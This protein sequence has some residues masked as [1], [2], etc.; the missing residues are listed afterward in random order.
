MKLRNIAIIAHVDHGKTTLVDRLLQ[1][2]GAFRE[3]QRVAERVMDSNDLERERGITILAKATSVVWKGVRVNI[4]DTPGHADFGG[5]VERILSMVDGAIVLV[6][7]AEGPMPQ[8]KFV[9]GKALKIGLKPIVC[10]NK[11]DKHDAR[12][13]E[14]VNEC[15]DLFAALDATDEQLDFPII[16]G[17][18]KQGWMANS[19][20]GP[21]ENMAPL[22]DLVLSHVEPPKVGA[23][24]FRMLGTLLEANPYLGRIITG[25]IFSG[26]IK[27][28]APVKVL[29]RLGH[30][31]ETGRVS[32]ILAFRGIE[33]SPIEEASAG[34]IVA[35][36]GLEKF[37]VADTL[38]SPE[39]VEPLLAQ[40][41]DPPTLSMTFM[42]NDS[43]L[44]GTEGDKVTS[45][46]IRDRLFKEA[47]GNVALRVDAAPNSD[48]YVVSGRGELQLAI[49][50]ETMRRE[51][52]ELGVSRPKVLFNRDE[53]SGE[54]LEPIEEVVI[55]V[56]EEHSGV[57]VQKMS[58][59][60][61]EMIEMRPS[62][63][64]RL[65]LVFLAPTRGLIG[66]L[67]ELLTDT[68]GT[69]IMNRVFHD[70]GA[71]RGEIAGRRN[72]V[73]IS[74]EKGEAVAYAMWNLED[75]GPMMIEPGWKV[76]QGMI[77]GQHSRDNDLEVNVLKGKKL[78]NIRT[79]SKDEAVRLTPP[80]QMTLEKALAY[81][82]DDELVEVTPKSIRLRKA[83]LD[84]NDRKRAER[85]KAAEGA[86]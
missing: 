78:T 83:L 73:L 2:S 58:E 1:Q 49:L 65:R 70:W 79:H 64:D 32:K 19:P 22:F 61:G 18:A 77:V 26:S 35:I 25:R 76:Y 52:F 36:A 40:P 5:E 72:G 28:N 4:V 12:P 9:V 75:R 51:G 43:P 81:I 17:S 50:I 34:D 48:A 82:Q 57:V 67:G 30:L 39:E 20:D 47:E 56:D 33:H 71:W 66:Y 85:A 6:D 11:V 60:K 69:A 55:D 68:R 10:V 84:P 29:D 62:G 54:L 45:R 3:N 37:N 23:G 41:I 44:A 7:A 46:V 80:I 24:G 16:Y 21:K 53:A 86:A 15:F 31:V 74:N 38:C 59:R 42:V 27:A 13:S 8:T 63:G 14:V